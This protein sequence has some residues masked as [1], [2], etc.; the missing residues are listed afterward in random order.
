MSQPPSLETQKTFVYIEANLILFQNNLAI[1]DKGF[2]EAG[3]VRRK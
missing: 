2:L 1:F 3:V